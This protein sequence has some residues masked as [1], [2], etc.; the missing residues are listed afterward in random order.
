MFDTL[1]S[2]LEVAALSSSDP[3]EATRAVSRVL[4]PW[5]KQP[6]PATHC[7]LGHGCYA[8]HLLYCDP[9][10][11]WCAVAIVLAPG[12]STPVHNH[13]TWGVIGV[14]QGRERELRYRRASD[15]SLEELAV[16]FNE[17][18]DVT[19]VVPP[20]DIHRIEGATTDGSPTVSIHVY[21]GDVDRVTAKVFEITGRAFD[22]PCATTRPGS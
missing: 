7:E 17:P 21:G 15:G 9:Q 4:A 22:G 10:A 16:R 8:R 3:R 13:T 2:E 11:R 1:V 12:Q 20:L 6:L 19:T 5:L 18:G 14:V